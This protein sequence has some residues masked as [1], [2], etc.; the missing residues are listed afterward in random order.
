MLVATRILDTTN[1]KSKTN[2]S[3]KYILCYLRSLFDEKGRGKYTERQLVLW[4][5]SKPAKSENADFATNHFSKMIEM[6]D[7]GFEIAEI[8]F[9][10]NS[11]LLYMKTLYRPWLIDIIDHFCVK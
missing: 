11:H 3:G 10:L 1:I 8:W 7:F 5:K 2:H 9:V 6:I 4:Y